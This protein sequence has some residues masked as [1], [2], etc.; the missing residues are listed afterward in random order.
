MLTG[1]LLLEGLS[2]GLFALFLVHLQA[3]EISF[4][5]HTRLE[6]EA[7]SLALL[8]SDAFAQ[9]R[10]DGVGLSV[11]MMGDAPTVALAKVT[12]QAGKVLSVS[13]GR[14]EESRLDPEEAALIPLLRRGA[15]SCFTFSGDR[16]ECAHAIVVAHATRGFAWVEFDKRWMHAQLGDLWNDLAARLRDSGAADGAH[17]YAAAGDIARRRDFTDVRRWRPRA[18]SATDRRP[19]RDRRP[20]RD[21]Q[22]HGGLA[23]RAAGGVE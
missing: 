2:I 17:D 19:Q 13:K 15:V 4:R 3:R 6:Y 8:A 10:S 20:D 11:K 7:E 23:G 5:A 14:A 12:D 21:L 1:L 9:Q 16:W 22:S 18:L